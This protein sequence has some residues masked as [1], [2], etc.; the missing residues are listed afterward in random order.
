MQHKKR[1]GKHFHARTH[2][3]NDFEVCAL[4]LL[5]AIR[6]TQQFSCHLFPPDHLLHCSLLRVWLSSACCCHQ[7]PSRSAATCRL[8][9]SSSYGSGSRRR[10]YRNSSL[11]LLYSRGGPLGLFLLPCISPPSLGYLSTGLNS[12]GP[13]F[14]NS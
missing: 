7:R 13:G 2:H 3:L 14:R 8:Y 4:A 12:K 11:A 9:Q 1:P 6:T 10:R 5:V